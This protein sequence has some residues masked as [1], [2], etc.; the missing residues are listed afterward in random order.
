M[1]TLIELFFLIGIA[2]MFFTDYTPESS[3]IPVK[4]L[5]QIGTRYLKNG[6]CFDLIALLPITLSFFH[7]SDYVRLFYLIKVWLIS[8]NNLIHLDLYQRS[9]KEKST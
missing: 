9:A 5:Q 2:K 3:N 6:F 1:E 7:M 4:N 8:A